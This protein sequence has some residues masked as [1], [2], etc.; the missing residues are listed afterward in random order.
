MEQYTASDQENLQ[1]HIMAGGPH[2]VLLTANAALLSPEASFPT[3]DINLTA[4]ET[5]TPIPRLRSATC[6]KCS[7]PMSAT[8][9]HFLHVQENAFTVFA[10]RMCEC[11]GVFL[12]RGC[13]NASVFFCC[14]DVWMHRCFSA[15]WMCECIG[16]FLLRGCVNALLVVTCAQGCSRC[17]SHTEHRTEDSAVTEDDGT[18]ESIRSQWERTVPRERTVP[19]EQAAGGH[20]VSPWAVRP[21]V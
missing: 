14:V 21:C 13:V 10:L 3:S 8:I 18:A 20:A 11:I 15:A 2:V 12:L 16:V 7:E 17:Q 19:Q 1:A 9:Y 5:I 4:M 6:R